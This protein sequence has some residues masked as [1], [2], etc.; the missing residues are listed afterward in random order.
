MNRRQAGAW[1]AAHHRHNPKPPRG[2]KF[3]VA[4]ADAEGTIWGVAMAG[5][6]IS[7]PE[8]DGLT[9]EVYRSVT[10]PDGPKNVNSFL[11][12]ACW[13]SAREMGYLRCVSRTQG[14]EPGT[15]LRAAGYRVIAERPP[16]PNWAADTAN[17]R[18]RAMRDPDGPGGVARKVWLVLAP[19]PG[20]AEWCANVTAALRGLDGE[21]DQTMTLFDFVSEGETDGSAE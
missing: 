1:V 9:I 14:D 6:P 16:R 12:A 3:A 11:Y 4:A 21:R 13:R 7:R 15:S 10:L 19:E 5:R 17:A 8:D 20:G 2:Y 18:L